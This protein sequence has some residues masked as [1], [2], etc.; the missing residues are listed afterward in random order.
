ML[1]PN[2]VRYRWLPLYYTAGGGWAVS[3]VWIAIFQSL[4]IQNGPKSMNTTS[5][6]QELVYFHNTC[7]EISGLLCS[8]FFYQM[9]PL[10]VAAERGHTKIVD[11]LVREGA[12]IDSQDKEGVII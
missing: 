5:D 9:T 11:Y 7:L 10:H 1:V 6:S 12:D 4:H 3:A 2:G 8:Y